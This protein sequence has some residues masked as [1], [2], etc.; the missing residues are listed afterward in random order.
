M[1]W[2]RLGETSTDLG[3][4]TFDWDRIDLTRDAW[5]VVMSIGDLVGCA[6]VNG[7]VRH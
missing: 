6:A 2:P 5:L 4:L 1:P 3:D 7:K